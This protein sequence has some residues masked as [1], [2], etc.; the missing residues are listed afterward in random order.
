MSTFAPH[1]HSDL[2]YDSAQQEQDHLQGVNRMLVPAAEH[3]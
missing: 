2:F 3:L 1:H